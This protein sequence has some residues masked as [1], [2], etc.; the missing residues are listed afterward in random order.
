[1]QIAGRAS[2]EFCVGSVLNGRNKVI[3]FRD[4]DA[5]ECA[6]CFI[7]KSASL[8]HVRKSCLTGSACSTESSSLMR[9]TAPPSG[10]NGA[11]N[12]VIIVCD[13]PRCVEQLFDFT[14]IGL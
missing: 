11:D 13:K 7:S 2:L 4:A 5:H 6:G 9:V 8:Q 14:V 10:G 1:M 12:V 3:G